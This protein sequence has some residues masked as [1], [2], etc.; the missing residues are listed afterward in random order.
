MYLWCFKCSRRNSK[1]IQMKNSTHFTFM[2]K[3]NSLLD[4]TFENCISEVIT[5][6]CVK[7][8]AQWTL[9]CQFKRLN[10]DS[11]LTWVPSTTQVSDQVVNL[12]VG[13]LVSNGESDL[14][15]L[16]ELQA[17]MW[18]LTWHLYTHST[19]LP[20]AKT[21]TYTYTNDHRMCLNR[22]IQFYWIT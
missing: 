12:A 16:W 22:T 6:L 1:S 13:P 8:K 5:R 15:H 11:Q 7:T 14:F 9:R 18:G 3:I 10:T 2:R 4:H 19:I 20:L 17:E 21:H